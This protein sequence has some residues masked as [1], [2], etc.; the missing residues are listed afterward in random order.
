M[1][2]FDKKYDGERVVHEPLIRALDKHTHCTES[3]RGGDPRHI[4]RQ[5]S[6]QP[7]GRSLTCATPARRA[8]ALV[9]VTQRFDTTNHFFQPQQRQHTDPLENYYD[10]DK[11]MDHHCHDWRPIKKGRY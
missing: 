5:R 4:H 2:P 7:F 9:S 3:M 8:R 11:L 6:G 1:F 10:F